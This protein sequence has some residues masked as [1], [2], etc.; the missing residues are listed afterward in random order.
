MT[1]MAK[2]KP[3]RKGRKPRSPAPPSVP[4][5]RFASIYPGNP[6]HPAL[7]SRFALPEEL[8][9]AIHELEVALSLPVWMLLQDG[10]DEDRF[11]SDSFNMVGNL[12]A[13]AFFEARHSDLKKGEKIA[14]LIDSNGG[15]A[16][17]SYELAML[18]RRHCG[19]FV[20]VIPRHAKSAA[21]LLSLGADRIVMNDHAELGPLDVQMY[22]PDREDVMSGLDEVQSLERLQAFAMEAMDRMMMLLIKRTK[23][24]AKNLIPFVTEFVSQL[25][26]PMFKGIDVVRYTQMSRA[27][28]VAEE[29]G[30]RLLRKTYGEDAD[31]IAR[32]L[33]ENYPDHAFPIYPHEVG[34]IGIRLAPLSPHLR[35]VLEKVTQH[36]PN[37]N[38]VGRII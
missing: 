6:P 36:L 32:K 3:A 17:S 24:K 1:S 2:K 28:K 18:L 16:R 8:V 25:T 35:T 29:Y 19:G 4:T 34:E 22:D 11:T 20:A 5:E 13:S 38:A 26:H 7:A 10:Q 27:L 31:E 23:K 33:V 21:T 9:D 14:L 37:L 15:L 12:V 30:K